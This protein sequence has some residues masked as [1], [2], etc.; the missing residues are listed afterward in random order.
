MMGYVAPNRLSLS[1]TVWAANPS[2]VL[3]PLLGYATPEWQGCP[4]HKRYAP[5]TQPTDCARIWWEGL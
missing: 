2:Y 4:W 3:A 1:G 5:L